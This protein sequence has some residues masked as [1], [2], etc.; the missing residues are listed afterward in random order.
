MTLARTV[1]SLA[2]LAIFASTTT[3]A[4]TPRA[5]DLELE[6]VLSKARAAG[7]WEAL[8]ANREG[9]LLE[10]AGERLGLTTRHTLLFTP[11]G[12]FRETR[13]GRLGSVLAF[14][15]K[16]GWAIEWTGLWAPLDP[17]DLHGDQA[18]IWVSTGCWLSPEIPLEIS[19][20]A[21]RGDDEHVVLSLLVSGSEEP[22]HLWLD[23][24][25]WLPARLLQS[26]PIGESTTRFE[27]YRTVLGI[28]LPHRIETDVKGQEE[29]WTI[30]TVQAASRPE[31]D[32][33]TASPRLPDDTEFDPD[34]E[35]RIEAKKTATGHLL[36]RPLLEG[37]EIGWVVLD[38]GAGSMVIDDDVGD[39]L[40]LPSFGKVGA[41]GVGGTVMTVFREAAAIQLGPLTFDGPIYFI[42]LDLD[43]LGQAMGEKLAGICG[44]D[45]LS[46]AVVTIDVVTPRISIHD[47]ES[48]ELAGGTWEPLTIMGRIPCVRA[49]FEGDREGLFRI[50][51]GSANSVDFHGGAVEKFKLLENRS[52]TPITLGGVGGTIRSEMGTLD[53]F[54]LARHRFEKPTVTFARAGDGAFTDRLTLGTIGGRFLAPFTMVLN[55]PARKVAF[56]EKA[57]GESKH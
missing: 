3:S 19:L 32:P 54:E 13:E 39:E 6:E 31:E 21:A 27:N 45:L 9:V 48:Y 51:T 49:R 28:A 34:M 20:D 56:V 37:E 47:P 8:A 44:Y 43:P 41:T 2:L 10:G 36:V 24:T 18:R 57:A 16:A 55:Y 12:K 46:R 11:H 23:R 30:E 17:T 4:V 42:E 1:S 52:T 5:P 25:T 53:W 38:T 7:G 35:A 22:C 26:T 15:G 33:F 14:D 50:D 29:H 40:G